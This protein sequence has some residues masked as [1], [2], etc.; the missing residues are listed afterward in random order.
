MIGLVLDTQHLVKLTFVHLC[1]SF[2][3][4]VERHLCKARTYD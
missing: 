2:V 4:V 1:G 3:W